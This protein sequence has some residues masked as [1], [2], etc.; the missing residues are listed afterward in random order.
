MTTKQGSLALLDDPVAQK[1]LQSTLDLSELLELI[2]KIAKTE[3]RADRGTVFL[4][5]IKSRRVIWSVYERPKDFTPKQ[6]DRAAA[7]IVNRLKKD[8]SGQ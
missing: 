8:I 4:V 3:C 7:R 5:D 6:L 2:L 1:L